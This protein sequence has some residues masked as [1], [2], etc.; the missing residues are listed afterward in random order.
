MDPAWIA[1]AL[2][3]VSVAIALFVAVANRSDKSSDHK[4]R[5]ATLESA[6]KSLEKQSDAHDREISKIRERWHAFRNGTLRE[7]AKHMH[8]ITKP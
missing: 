1:V 3:A 7:Y 8:E 5:I 4:E 6:V 2:S